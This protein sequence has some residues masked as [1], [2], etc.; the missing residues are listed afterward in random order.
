MV[1]YCI[2]YMWIF[3]LALMLISVCKFGL[4]DMYGV[5][6][7][8]WVQMLKNG[9]VCDFI[10]GSNGVLVVPVWRLKKISAWY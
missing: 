2:M 9:W 4:D 1:G 7:N 5:Y 8:L 6:V 3:V 10:D